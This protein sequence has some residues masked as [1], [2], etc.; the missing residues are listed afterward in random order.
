MIKKKLFYK[1][2]LKFLSFLNRNV[3]KQHNSTVNNTN[4]F[5]SLQS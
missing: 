4:L 5:H 1:W 2:L 3:Y